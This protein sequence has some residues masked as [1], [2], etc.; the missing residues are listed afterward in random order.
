MPLLYILDLGMGL[1]LML[2]DHLLTFSREV[3]LVWKAPSSFGRNAFLVNNYLV[4]ACLIIAAHRE[5][6]P[7]QIL[8]RL[9]L[10]HLFIVS[11]Q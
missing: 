7:Q 11:L 10:A 9:L 5:F 1:A 3:K 6:S 2:Y 4:I 8:N